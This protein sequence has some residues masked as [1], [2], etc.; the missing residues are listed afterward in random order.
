MYQVK[1]R[2]HIAAFTFGA[3]FSLLASKA[4]IPIYLM[5]EYYRAFDVQSTCYK[6][7][8]EIKNAA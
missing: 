3:F 4:H 6:N 7:H 2:P 1:K 5:L 8:T